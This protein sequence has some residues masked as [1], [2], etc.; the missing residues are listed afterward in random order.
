MPCDLERIYGN[1][2]AQLPETS[3][4]G[5]RFTLDET[6]ISVAPA[7]L[8]SDNFLVLKG[9]IQRLPGCRGDH[10][11][12]V[13]PRSAFRQLGLLALA[14]LFHESCDRSTI[15]ITNP[16]SRIKHLVLEYKHWQK[17]QVG[18][19]RVRPWVLGYVPDDAEPT[20]STDLTG[21]GAPLLRLTNLSDNQKDERDWQ[22]R[23]TL[24][25][26]GGTAATA[27]VAEYL[28][29]AGRKDAKLGTFVIPANK[30][31][32]T[33]EVQLWVPEAWELLQS[34]LRGQS[35]NNLKAST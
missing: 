8:S 5:E 7:E 32:F 33:A 12:I 22:T 15:H 34:N 29:N 11:N 9:L 16:E 19:F 24:W 25:G 26:F 21:F 6:V 13:A 2:A 1:L 35:Q 4:E 28:L 23:D 14:V 3:D 18:G 10:I 31:F 30:D 17:T 20:H 27:D